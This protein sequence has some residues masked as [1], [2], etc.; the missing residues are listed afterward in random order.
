MVDFIVEH[1]VNFV[2]T[3]AGDPGKYIDVLKSADITVYHAVPSLAKL[4][5]AW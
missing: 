1:G 3:S 4:G 5:T 2:T